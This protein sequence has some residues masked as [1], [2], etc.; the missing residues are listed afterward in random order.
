MGDSFGNDKTLPRFERHCSS[1][2]VNQELPLNHIEKLIV[3]V[4]FVPV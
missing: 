1:L 4:V 2:Q 3:I